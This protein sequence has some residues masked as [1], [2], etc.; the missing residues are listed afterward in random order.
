VLFGA[1]TNRPDLVDSSTLRA[2]RFDLKLPFLLPDAAAREAIFGVTFKTLRVPQGDL[3]LKAFGEKTAGYSGADLKELIRVAQRRA[4]FGGRDVVTEDDL[5][6]A[7]EDYLPPS[8]ARQ[9]EIRLME[10]LAVTNCTSRSLLPEAYVRGLTD[11]TMKA[12][13]AQLQGW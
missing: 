7:L 9:D 10:L 13:L 5:R 6:Y 4:V 2:G 11:G 3:D 12:E 1:A 8:A